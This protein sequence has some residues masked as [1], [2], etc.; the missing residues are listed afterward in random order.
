MAPLRKYGEAF[1]QGASQKLLRTWYN[2][3]A[4]CYSETYES[5]EHYGGRGI[6]VCKRWNRANSKGFLNFFSDM[7]NPPDEM[8]LDRINVDGDYSP[9]NCRWASR[10]Q[11][12]MGRRK[13]KAIRRFTADEIAEDLCKRSISE[14]LEIIKILLSSGRQQKK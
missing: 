4:R 14:V 3:H 13:F 10:T 6:K 5:W 9:S 12:S 2:M 8:S 1:K 11:Q 7:G